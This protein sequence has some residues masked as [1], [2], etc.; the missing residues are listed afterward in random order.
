MVFAC[1]ALWVKSYLFIL[2]AAEDV[3]AVVM[4]EII[5]EIVEDFL[6]DQVLFLG[7]EASDTIGARNR[8]ASDKRGV[9]LFP[10]LANAGASVGERACPANSESIFTFELGQIAYGKG[11]FP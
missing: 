3:E 10:C 7:N 5:A 1:S 8:R 9:I 11:G 4:S 6:D 2:A